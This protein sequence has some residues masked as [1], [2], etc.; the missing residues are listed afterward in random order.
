M[1]PKVRHRRSTT[2]T[3]FKRIPFFNLIILLGVGCWGHALAQTPPPL[4]IKPLRPSQ[5]ASVMQTVGVTD[6]TITYYRPGVKGRLIFADAPTE[7]EARH[8][9]E[10]TLDN[11]KT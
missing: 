5:G 1:R 7:M 4:A 2:M 3:S 11:Q 10:A 9:G 8:P 6:I